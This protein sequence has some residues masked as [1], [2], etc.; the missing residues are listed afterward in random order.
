MY[1]ESKTIRG[2]DVLWD[3]ER[4]KMASVGRDLVALW[5]D[6]SLLHILA[7][8]RDELST[9]L[10]Q[11]L[12]AHSSSQGTKADYETMV[13]VFADNFVDGFLAWGRAVGVVGWG[14]FEVPEFDVASGSAR[15]LVRSPWELVMQRSLDNPWG[16]P[17]LRGKL[18]GIFRY[19]LGVNCWADERA[20]VEDGE[21]VVEFTLY[22]STMTIEAELDRLRREFADDRAAALQA[23]VDLRTEQ[24]SRSEER[25]RTT[26]ASLSSWVIT[27][28]G[29]GRVQSEHRPEGATFP[30]VALGQRLRDVLPAAAAD[31]LDAAARQVLAAGA[32]EVLDVTLVRDG[33]RTCYGVSVSPRRGADGRSLGVTLVVRDV[34]EKR[35]AEEVRAQ[36]EAQLH[37]AQKMEAIGQL[38]GGVAHDFNNLLTAILCNL[39]FAT[40]EPISAD[41]R[42]FIE[43]AMEAAN[44]AAT[45]THQLLAFSRKKPLQPHIVDPSDLLAG[46]EA[47]LRRTL[48]ERYELR[49]V[50]APGQWQCEVDGS[51][52]E[53]AILNLVINA[54]DAMPDG[55]K[56]TIETRNV[57]IST[58][59]ADAHEGLAPGPYVLVAVSDTG[60][61][62]TEAVQKRAFEPFFT[63]KGLGRGSGLGLSMVYG[64]VRQ[65]R[66]HVKIYSE[67]GVGT[68]VKLYFPRSTDE[69]AAHGGAL[70]T[71]GPVP[72]GDGSVVLVVEDD[73]PVRRVSVHI[74]EGLGYA[75][76]DCG[77]A[78]A[79]LEILRGPARVDLLFTDVVL[80]GDVNGA[81]LAAE[82]ARLR[83]GLAVLYTSGY[84]ENAILHHGRLDPGIQLLEKPFTKD[85]LARRIHAAL[86]PGDA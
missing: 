21:P 6:P 23:E 29:E 53:S 11:L 34:T 38:T 3:T 42:M 43:E 33:A 83:P 85:A 27:I 71:S 16:C 24:L 81:Q 32:P 44:K 80:P 78:A 75:T 52:L 50:A 14:R 84:T 66:G 19:A 4:G 51:Q 2:I 12:V 5:L 61:G 65:S 40:T 17:F 86:A 62:M 74:L 70:R 25:L 82:A 30:A 79:A 46:L 22:R 9:E 36:L 13:S 76:L 39:E 15:V 77:N 69:T 26:L 55:G 72:R 57:R 63:T 10:F 67:P 64:F 54:R 18:I 1:D 8:L 7:P 37:Q 28:D 41:A 68:T 48:G 73:A 60:V 20:F 45:L 35:R 59:Y 31:E 47:L 56:I 58:E 49:I